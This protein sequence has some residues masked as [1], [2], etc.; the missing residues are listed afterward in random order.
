MLSKKIT[1]QTNIFGIIANPIK[2]VITPELFNNLFRKINYNGVYIPFHLNNESGITNFL[3]LSKNCQNI[4]GINVSIPY[5]SKVIDYIDVMNDNV[6]E[7]GAANTLYLK[8]GKCYG[9]NFDGDAYILGLKKE[10][11]LQLKNKNIL[12]FGAGG[13]AKAII[14]HLILEKVNKIIIINRTINNALKIS[15]KYKKYNPKIECYSL[16]ETY[17]INLKL[18]DLFINTTP[19][20]YSR[21]IFPIYN[22]CEFSDNVI[23]SDII[24]KPL[25][26]NLIKAAK[27]IGLKTYT[28]D[29]MLIYQINN[30]CKIWGI[31]NFSVSLIKECFPYL[32]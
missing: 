2:Q 11:S 32:H 3:E 28:G 22:L 31:G 15:N 10:I 12:I 9:Y 25:E 30:M 1:G 29:N 20:N 6:K 17:K 19:I 27:E 24:M 7:T 4:I 14:Y 5:K 16:N 13:S 21:D 18:I 8:N 23:I 26:T